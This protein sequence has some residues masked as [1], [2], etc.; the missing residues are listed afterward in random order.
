[1]KKLLSFILCCYAITAFADNAS[2]PVAEAPNSTKQK[3]QKMLSDNDTNQVS[4]ILKK[5]ELNKI[6]ATGG[7]QENSAPIKKKYDYTP[8]NMYNLQS[9]SVLEPIDVKD[10]DNGIYISKPPAKFEKF[11]VTP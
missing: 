5:D 1:M 11:I 3:F 6:K 10:V 9:M 7:V 4:A 2:E 8:A